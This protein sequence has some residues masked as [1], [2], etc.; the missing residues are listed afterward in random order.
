[1]I[2]AWLF[3]AAFLIFHLV[4]APPHLKLWETEPLLIYGVLLLVLTVIP[5]QLRRYFR[6]SNPS[7]TPND[8]TRNA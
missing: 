4:G 8:N 1:M 5:I 3:V 7:E 6:R 2:A